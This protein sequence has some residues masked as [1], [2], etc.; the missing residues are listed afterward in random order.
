MT[1]DYTGT[2][3][4]SGLGGESTGASDQAKHAA[5]TAADE[6]KHVA[7][8]AQDEAKR[9]ASEAKTQLQ[10]LL[11]QTTREVDDQSRSQ[12]NRL[13]ETMRTFGDDL[14]QMS[15]QGQ[16]GMAASLAR[17]VAERARSMSSY[18]DKREPRELLDDVRDFAR[19]KPG[20]FLLGA[21]AA[22]VV[23]GRLTRGAKQA[24]DDTSSTSVS[25]V[26]GMGTR[27]TGSPTYAADVT[28]PG[29]PMSGGLAAPSSGVR[30]GAT[31]GAG[32][33]AGTPLAGTG[34]PDDLGR[35][36]VGDPLTDPL[37]TSTGSGSATTDP[38][39]PG[40]RS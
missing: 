8:V 21:M 5:G 17:E 24:H 12:K 33:S 23:A 19:R 35:P 37:S 15:S 36:P 13:A 29:A 27:P 4:T 18:L 7:G 2:P 20:T 1:T 39:E 30:P 16:D 38:S 40:G 32:T 28:S 11:D 25:G 10:G 3:G 34:T 9:V 6:T 31:A 26:T 22:G 14:D